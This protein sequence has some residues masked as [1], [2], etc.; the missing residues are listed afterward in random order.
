MKTMKQYAS[1]RQLWQVLL[2]Y[3]DEREA[4]AVVRM[5]LEERFGLTLTD[6]VCD[7]VAR[8]DAS[9]QAE[10]QGMVAKLEQGEPIQYVMGYAPF[11]GRHFHVEP[12]VLIPRPE[13]QQLV[14]WAV[15]EI[16]KNAARS[17]LDIGTGS[18]CIAISI[19]LEAPLSEVSAWDIS[20][21]ALRIARGNA[22]SLHA[23]VDF[24][25]QDALHAPMED[26]E[27]WDLIISNPPYVMEK[28][29]REMADNVL[30]HEPSLALF[31]PNDDP[32]RFYRAIAR[33][34][35]HAL[36]PGGTLLFEI[37]PLL[38]EDMLRLLEDESYQ[39]VQLIADA[40]G[41]SR[42][43]KATI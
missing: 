4:Q 42:F 18:G 37:N 33:Y 14:E 38:A 8:L 6:I 7:G 28:E 21:D 16:G 1:Y 19:A 36:R 2:P 10:L 24:R 3:Y 15:E 26:R 5:M 41:K 17:V 32:L 40:F 22:A 11:Y 12:G 9:Q 34:G 31:V 20:T 25:Q 29:R 30:R 43:T 23:V 13:T 35:K 27:K 39:H